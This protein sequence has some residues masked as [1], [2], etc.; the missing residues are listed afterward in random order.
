MAE[1][2]NEIAELF[3]PPNKKNIMDLDGSIQNFFDL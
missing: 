3:G 1:N 2:K